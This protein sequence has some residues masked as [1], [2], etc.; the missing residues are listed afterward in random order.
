M[1]AVNAPL[2]LSLCIVAWIDRL[3]TSTTALFK[4]RCAQ[5]T[6][7]DMMLIKTMQTSSQKKLILQ[8]E[9]AITHPRSLVPYLVSHS[10]FSSREGDNLL[11]ILHCTG[12]HQLS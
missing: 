9:S 2:S 7:T 5:L 1:I 12:H 11:K 4:S 3:D 10:V 6:H 8:P